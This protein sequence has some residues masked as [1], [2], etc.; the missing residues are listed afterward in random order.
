MIHPLANAICD[1]FA[2]SQSPRAHSDGLVRFRFANRVLRCVDVP[3]G[4]TAAF[5]AMSRVFD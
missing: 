5:L 1:N 2:E 3:C 4:R